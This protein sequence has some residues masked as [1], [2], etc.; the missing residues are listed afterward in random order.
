[1][2][3]YFIGETEI[4]P[5]DYLETIKHLF[6]LTLQKENIE[7]EVEVSVKFVT[8]EEIEQLNQQYR[9]QSSP[10]DVLSFPIYTKVE[11]LDIDETVPISL[12]DIVIST[13]KAAEQASEYNHSLFREYSF[14]AIHGLLHLLGYDHETEEDEQVMFAKQHS[15]LKEFNIVR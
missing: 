11:L 12:G 6:K 14:L 9:N 13:E 8:N 4:I 15:L 10:T 2:E 3:V 1:M 5:D 7:N